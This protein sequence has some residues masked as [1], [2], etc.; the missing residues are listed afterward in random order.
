VAEYP[1]LGH[2]E[3]SQS[4][5][6]AIACMMAVGSAARLVDAMKMNQPHAESRKIHRLITVPKEK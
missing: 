1:A 6:L 2:E 5:H 3:E 4:V